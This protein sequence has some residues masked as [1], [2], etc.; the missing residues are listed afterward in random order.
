VDALAEIVSGERWAVELKW[1]SKAV[2]EKGLSALAAR[3]RPLKSRPRCVSRSG[4]T[5]DARAYAEANDIL[6][7]MR[8]DLEKIERAARSMW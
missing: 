6:I 7:S 4:F 3:A 2:G 8:A 5:P 1:Q